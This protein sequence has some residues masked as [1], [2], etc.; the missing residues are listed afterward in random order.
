MCDV[1][2]SVVRFV[3]L[4]LAAGLL[5]AAQL[6]AKAQVGGQVTINKKQK[7]AHARRETN[8]SREARIQRTIEDTYSHRYEIYG[9]GGF[10]RFRSGSVTQRNN[11]VSWLMSGNYYLNPK[12]FI[13]GS[14]QGSFGNAKPTYFNGFAQSSNPQ[15]NEYFFTGGA[16]YRFYRKEKFALS[17][18]GQAGIGWGIFSGGSKGIPSVDLGMWQDGTRP[19][20]QL[21]LNADYNFYPNLAFRV[22]PTWTGTTFVAAPGTPSSSIQSDMGFNAGFV[23]RF[24]RQK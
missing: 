16:G 13:L 22:S 1:R 10:L 24:G 18:Q 7:D 9:G 4:G 15:I 6:P 2:K 12:L 3:A 17:A 19:A 23:Y 11:E 5:S 20:F 21:A 8:A 14:A